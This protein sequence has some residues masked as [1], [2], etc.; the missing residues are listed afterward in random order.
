LSTYPR[1]LDRDIDLAASIGIDLVFA[2]DVEE[3][4]PM[5]PV[6][7]VSL[8]AVAATSEGASRP[9]HFAGVCTVVA[10]LFNIA[11]PCR[12]YFSVKDYQQ[13]IIVTRMARDP[14]FPGPVR[15]G[16]IRREPGGLPMSS[17][18]VRL[19]PADRAAAPV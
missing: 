10:K 3:M 16:P 12:A 15:P 17:R 7:S 6:T 19:G 1:D 14:S 9:S 11:G 4:Y 18:N 2:P 8:R 13:L 5:A